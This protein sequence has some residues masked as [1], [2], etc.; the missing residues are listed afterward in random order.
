MFP[1]KTEILFCRYHVMKAFK[2]RIGKNNEIMSI[3]ENMVY[4]PS[5]EAHLKLEDELYSL[6]GQENF[7]TYYRTNWSKCS[8]DWI[9][10][11]RLK[12]HRFNNIL[13]NKVENSTVR[14][15]QYIKKNTKLNV[16][17][18]GLLKYILYNEKKFSYA[19]FIDE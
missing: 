11:S 6:K 1:S 12:L 2:S 4:C 17:I 8:R 15:K 14:L 13:N 9:H 10:A 3:L 18:Q 5:N 7:K 16:S 19:S